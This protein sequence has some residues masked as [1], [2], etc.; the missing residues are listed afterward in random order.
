M[1]V[2]AGGLGPPASPARSQRRRHRHHPAGQQDTTPDVVTAWRW[3]L[4]GEPLFSCPDLYIPPDA[5]EVFSKPSGPLDLLLYLIR[6]QNFN[7]LDIPL[8]GHA[9]YL[10]YVEQIRK[11]NLELAAEYLLM[12]AMPCS[13]SR[14]CCCRPRRP[15]PARS[16]IRA[17][18]WYAAC[19]N[20]SRSS[21]PPRS[22]TSCRRSAAFARQVHIEQT[23]VTR[24]PEVDIDDLK[25]VWPIS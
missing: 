2:Q 24:W 3:R 10:E 13:S 18:S 11:Q 12:A 5:L 9:Q 7:I 22:W 1:T 8:A 15:S 17:P 19:W 25:A 4:Y 23:V 20:T 6:K 14:A 21:W 16:R